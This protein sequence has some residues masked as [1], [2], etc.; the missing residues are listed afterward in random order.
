MPSQRTVPPN[1]INPHPVPFTIER[2]SLL[3]K[4][5]HLSDAES[6][7]TYGW[8]FSHAWLNRATKRSAQ[9]EIEKLI[10]STRDRWVPD[11]GWFLR[12]HIAS[13]RT[14]LFVDVWRPSTRESLGLAVDTTDGLASF[15]ALGDDRFQVMQS[16][17]EAS[18]PI[19]VLLLHLLSSGARLLWSHG[20]SP[21]RVGS[22][23]RAHELG[24]QHEVTDFSNVWWDPFEGAL[25]EVVPTRC[26]PVR[27]LAARTGMAAA[28]AFQFIA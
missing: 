8:R 4:H 21:I 25:Y 9:R 17:V 6:Y 19:D 26:P 5:P 11:A 15:P 24:I 12:W 20:K 27:Q 3:L 23:S 2:M 7:N 13:R 10:A 14:V 18:T 1:P 16:R 22:S 28:S